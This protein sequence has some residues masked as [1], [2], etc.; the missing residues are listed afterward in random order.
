M[1]P[2]STTASIVAVIQLSAK[3]VQYISTASGSTKERQRLRREIQAC[4]DTLQ[5]LKDESDDSETGKSWSNTVKALEAPGAPLGRLWAIMRSLETSLEPKDGLAKA[6]SI[7]RWPF[8]EREVGKIIGSIEREKSL[9]QISLENNSRKLIQSIKERGEESARQLVELIEA[10]NKASKKQSDQLVQL[11]DGVD[12]L[13]ERQITQEVDTERRA[14]LD[15]LSPLGYAAMQ[16]DYVNRKQPGTGQWLLDEPKYQSWMSGDKQTLFCPGI[17]G[18]GKTILTSIVVDDLC[19]RFLDDPNTAVAYIYCNFRR[20]EEQKVDDLL[21]SLLEQFVEH[22]ATLPEF[23]RHL[24]VKHQ[25]QRTT[26][27]LGEIREGLTIVVQKHS[28]VFL[29]VDGLDECS[30]A[31]RSRDRFLSE[32]FNLQRLTGLNIFATSRFIPEITKAFEGTPS[33]EIRASD[34]DVCLYLEGRMPQLPKFV[35]RK[36]DLQDEIK[37]SI[38]QAVDGMFLLAQLYVESLTGKSSTKAV[39]NALS[40]LKRGSDVYH[41][42]YS[43]AM[44]RILGQVRDHSEL[45][46]LVLSWIACA[47]RP[48]TTVE[49]QHALAVEIGEPELDQDNLPDTDDLVTVCCGLVTVDDES[50]IIRLVHYTTQ[51]YFERTWSKWFSGANDMIVKVCLTY[52]SFDTFPSGPC[53]TQAAYEECLE[54][55][56][57][58]DYAAQQWGHQ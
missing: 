37:T 56:P 35:S 53:A 15:W 2:L 11:K 57:F 47:K 7:L 9:L 41:L 51:Q 31:D 54:S 19:N 23:V 39:R 48:L 50:G 40:R 22:L 18:A 4:D 38:I 49:L 5:Q 12:R 28:R 44:E 52:L 32:M 1:D 20:H 27:T 36:P 24:F 26:P 58:Y 17:P 45:A 34:G 13:H 33:V 3:V 10:V 30:A 6:F 55:Y 46:Q 21:K 14:I 29:A 8:A 16:N 43:D 25:K 42:A